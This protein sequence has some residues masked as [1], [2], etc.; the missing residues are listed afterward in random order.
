M[1]NHVLTLQEQGF[2]NF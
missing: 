2:H 1:V